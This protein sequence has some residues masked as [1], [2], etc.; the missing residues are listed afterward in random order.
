MVVAVD[1]RVELAAAPDPWRGEEIPPR[2]VHQHAPLLGNHGR[3]LLRERI[4]APAER[5]LD[6]VV[7]TLRADD[8]PDALLADSRYPLLASLRRPR[9]H[10]SLPHGALPSHGGKTVFR[11]RRRG[12]LPRRYEPSGA[13]PRKRC[14]EDPGA[15]HQRIDPLVQGAPKHRR[16]DGEAG[17]LSRPVEKRIPLRRLKSDP[18]YE[19]PPAGGQWPARS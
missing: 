12:R 16:S 11:G 4:T 7:I 5:A 13:A 15:C 1:R 19:G 9:S 6:D 18:S 10:A 14:R 17:R 3:I 8:A 2:E